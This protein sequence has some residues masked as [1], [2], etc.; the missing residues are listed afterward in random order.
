MKSMISDQS[1]ISALIP[2]IKKTFLS[3]GCKLAGDGM[4]TYVCLRGDESILIDMD[5][6]VSYVHVDDYASI[7]TYLKDL[8][9]QVQSPLQ[10]A[11]EWWGRWSHD[12]RRVQ[13]EVP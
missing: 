7:S 12:Q 10:F 11:L 1:L 2:G 9:R 5:R 4:F 6:V 8:T 13:S 3:H